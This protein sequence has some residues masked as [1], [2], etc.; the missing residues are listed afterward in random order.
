V[1]AN[2]T[3]AEHANFVA[4]KVVA[5][6]AAFLNGS[7][8]ASQLAR[9]AH[10]VMLELIPIADDLKAKAIIDPARL[11]AIAMSGAAAAQGE[12]RQDR[13]MHVMASLIE[14]VRHES[15]E[16]KRTGVQRS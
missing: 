13:W 1:H 12:T 11:L 4:A 3:P 6:A 2:F 15:S 5:Y 16:L 14:L 8:D 7:H 9:N 10:S